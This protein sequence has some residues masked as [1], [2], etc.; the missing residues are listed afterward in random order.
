MGDVDRWMSV[1]TSLAPDSYEAAREAAQ[2]A[3]T[4]HDPTLLLVFA[5]IGHDP[6]RIADALRAAAPGVPVLGCST[7]GEINPGGPYDGSV[8][9]TALGGSGFSV[10]TTAVPE[11]SG[12]QRDAGAEAARC[13]ADVADRPHRVLLLLTDGLARDQEMVIRGVY[14]VLGASVPLFGGAAG[15]GWRMSGTFQLHGTDVFTNGVVAAC[16]GSDAPIAIGIDHGWRPA[17][18]PLVVTRSGDGR[19]QE[20]DDEPALDAY[21]DRLGAPEEVY[22]DDV[23]LRHYVLSRPLGVQRRSGIEIRNMSTAVDVD[24]RTIGGGGNLS[25]GA[26][27]FAME[28]D[29]E[30][31]VTASGRACRSAIE[32]L[33]GCTPVGLLTLSCAACRAV[34]GDDGVLK[35]GARI[36]EEAGAIPYAGFY[37]YGEIAR[38]RGINGFHNQ[39]MVVLAFG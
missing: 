6:Y 23:A 29:E 20:L 12:R 10:S 33:E 39:T 7:H 8:V 15:D 34:L 28:G 32:Q 13:A 3:L 1:G 27:A 2:A 19:V 21:L 35:E 38:T 4:G 17:G 5:G 31:V 18:E 37:T 24:G 14:G 9:V 26:L 36:A 30:S 11:I 22:R 25:L 16:I